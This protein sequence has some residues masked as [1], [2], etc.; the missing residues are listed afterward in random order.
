MRV[1]VDWKSSGDAE[2][3]I[4]SYIVE[5]QTWIAHAALAMI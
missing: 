3:L 4:V 5:H 2:L 1:W